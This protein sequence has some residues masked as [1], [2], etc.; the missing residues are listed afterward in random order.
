[1]SSWSRCRNQVR[2]VLTF[3]SMHHVGRKRPRKILGQSRPRSNVNSARRRALTC[4]AATGSRQLETGYHGAWI[5][6][7]HVDDDLVRHYQAADIRA[8]LYLN[9]DASL[10]ESSYPLLQPWQLL[11]IRDLA[12]LLGIEIDTVMR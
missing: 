1:M 9:P 3:D 6:L 2:K 8:D 10:R 4:G 12:Y 5:W 7:P 11:E